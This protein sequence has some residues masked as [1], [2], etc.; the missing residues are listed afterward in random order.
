MV[1]TALLT[2]YCAGCRQLQ[3]TELGELYLAQ[4][5]YRYAAFC[6]EELVLLNPMDAIFHSRLADV[7]ALHL[8][9]LWRYR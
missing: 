2:L 6:Y 8:V 4:G 1:H 9:L 3:W 7:R 5:A